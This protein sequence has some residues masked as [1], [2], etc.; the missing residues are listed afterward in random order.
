MVSRGPAR[1]GVRR[2]A[3]I[4][5]IATTM[6]LAA[7]L[8][9]S[10]WT[11]AAK[12]LD[13]AVDGRLTTYNVNS[14]A[15]NASAGAQA[16]NRVLTGFGFHG[17]D[18]QVIAD[19][20]FG[21]VEVVG[22]IPLV[23]DYTINEKAVYSDGKP[24]TCEDMVLAWFA[25]S[26]RLPDFDA[27]STA[28]YADISTI[29][30]KP[31]Q[32]T[33]RVTFAPDRAFTDWTQLFAATTM[34]PWHVVADKIGGGID[35]V[36]AIAAN[37]VPAL[38]KIADFWNNQWNFGSDLDLS[39]FP[40]SGPYKL[41]GYNDDGSV[42]LVANDKWWGSPPVTKRVTVWPSGIDVQKRL[43]DGDLEVVDV[44]AGSAGTL[45]APDG[46][47]RTEEPGSGVE[48]LIFGAGGSVG[49][50]DVRRAVALCTPRDAI[51]GITGVPVMNARLDTSIGDSFASVEAAAEAGRFMR[52]D[53]VAARAAVANRPL[54]VRV[55][56]QAPN[57]R[58]AAI[59][60]AMAQACE[61]A[62]ITVQDVS[63][64]EIGPRSL[65]DNQVD[66][67]L[68]SIGGA[69]GSGSTGSWLMDAYA[70]RSREG[71]NPANYA[72]GQIDGI[73]AALAVTTNARDQ[74]RLLGDASAILW[75]DLP[76]LPLY[77][78]PRVLIAPKSMYAATPSVTRWGAG[79]NMDRWVL[80]A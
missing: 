64:P 55:G 2:I 28:G 71:K 80:P 72:N 60:S 30:C 14:V 7:G 52:S 39:K 73:I 15:G 75:N 65:R 59:V 41:D 63:S 1:T 16:F 27:A 70:L 62:G 34:L 10:C 45:T 54:T 58:R 48:Q 69:P 67:L 77:R 8:L 18:G 50:P 31:G 66:A 9:T 13:Y 23:L 4:G 11:S 79:W 17:P 26:G 43:S 37:D 68:S 6:V 42:V 3:R 12:T 5:A 25:Q 76:T 61:A 53:P 74:S 24:V 56:Y 40:S 22:R 20:D 78:Q 38:Q 44:A 36:G 21:T 47:V 46:F 29:D 51:A 49:A 35:L 32:K 57:P 33:A 19:H